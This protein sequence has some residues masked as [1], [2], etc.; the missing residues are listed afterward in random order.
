MKH[1][2]NFFKSYD[3]LDLYYQIWRPDGDVKAVIQIV[4]GLGEYSTRYINVVNKLVPNGYLIYASDLRG[5]GK[6]KGIRAYVNKFEDFIKDQEKFTELIKEKIEDKSLFLLGHSLGSIISKAYISSAQDNFKGLILSGAGTK[7]GGSTNA[8]LI[9]FA[10][11]MSILTPKGKIS[12]KIKGED[13]SHDPEVIK[14]YDEDPLLLKEITIR[15]GAEMFRGNKIANKLTP[16][17]KIPTLVQFGSEDTLIL[18]ADKLEELMTMEDKTFK[19][20]DGLRHEVYN[21]L[22]EKREIVLQ[23][24]L[25]WLNKHT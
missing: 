6:S 7:I 18:G 14:N 17:I 10:K 1:E 8:L 11:L 24:L 2:D 23:D 3:D 20:Y 21:E 19:K 5:H 12:T 25:D 16:N 22:K 13:V 4:H 15:L 9:A